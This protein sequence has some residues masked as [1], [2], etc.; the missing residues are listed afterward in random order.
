M[1]FSIVARCERSGALGVAVSTAVPAVG[2]MCPYVRVG[3]G[4]V[5]TQSWVNPYLAMNALDLIERG[6]SAASALKMVLEADPAAGLR[7][8]GIVDRQG[9]T[10]TWTGPSCTEW[11]GHRTAA[12]VTIQ[13]N[14]LTGAATLDAMLEAFISSPG[15]SLEERLMRALEEGQ[16][17]GGDKRGRQSAALKVMRDEAYPWLDL[18]VDEHPEP[19]AELR[20]VFEVARHQFIP[21]VAGMPTRDDPGR[22]L[23]AAVAEMLLKS[24]GQRPGAFVHN[25]AGEMAVL[26]RWMGVAFVEDRIG[27]NLSTYR[28]ILDE[29][30]KLR[31]LDLSTLH[32]AVIFDPARVFKER[33]E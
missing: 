1:T 26:A 18:R 9:R 24:P 22:A 13:G 29:I 17:A 25:D 10:A 8:V 23:P 14:M 4:A 30:G 3:V 31:A 27:N 11:A 2:A 7:Q 6:E 15:E 21:F 20:R 16:A 12:G 19:V 32:P 5:S 33:S 28:S